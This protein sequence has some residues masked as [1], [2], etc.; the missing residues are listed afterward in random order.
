M[1]FKCP[2]YF[3]KWIWWGRCRYGYWYGSN[4]YLC[5]HPKL[6]IVNKAPYVA[7]CPTDGQKP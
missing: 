3:G 6:D 4:E 7:V 1:K 5:I 2:G